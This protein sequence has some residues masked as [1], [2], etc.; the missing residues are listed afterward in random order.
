MNEG[1]PGPL[2]ETVRDGPNQKLLSLIGI[3]RK[4]GR[5]SL[6][7][8]AAIEAIREGKAR[9]VIL[10]KDLSPRTARGIQFAAEEEGVL[11]IKAL[12]TMDEI[13]MALGKRTGIV[14]V[15]DAGFAKKLAALAAG[16]AK[17]RPNGEEL[18]YD[19]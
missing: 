9:L 12:E 2:T 17:Q 8:D 14:A 7:N 4:A 10:A 5:L 15:N 6:G 18:H 13:S 19:D 1:K 3:A 16:A 11:W